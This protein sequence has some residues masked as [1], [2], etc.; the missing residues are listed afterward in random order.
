MLSDKIEEATGKRPTAF[1]Y[2]FGAFSDCSSD[3]LQDIG[4]LATMTSTEGVNTLVRGDPNSLIHM[5]RY[6][7][8]AGESTERFMGR[9]MK[10]M[11]EG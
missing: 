7:R 6:T 1:A 11:G 9:I 4:F 2:P 5:D 8:K 10:T 3:A